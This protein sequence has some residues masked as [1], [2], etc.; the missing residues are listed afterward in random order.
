MTEITTVGIALAKSVFQVHG[1]DGEGAVVL[2]RQLRRSQVLDFFQRH[3][4]CLIGMEAP[5]QGRIIGRANSES[6][7][8]TL[9]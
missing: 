4:P 3:A 2:R 7:D 6:L 8:M 1:V 9:G 5:V